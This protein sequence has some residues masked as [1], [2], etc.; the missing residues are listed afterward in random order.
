MIFNFNENVHENKNGNQL[1]NWPENL[2]A[3][4]AVLAEKENI[5]PQFV[6]LTSNIYTKPLIVE[7]DAVKSIRGLD[8]TM[9]KEW[10]K[11]WTAAAKYGCEIKFK[12]DSLNRSHLIYRWEKEVKPNS[13]VQLKFLNFAVLPGCRRVMYSADKNKMKYIDSVL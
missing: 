9:S 6:T 4:E 7:Y 2:D 5:E 1:I 13:L 10:L 3:K 12:T 8:K 11:L